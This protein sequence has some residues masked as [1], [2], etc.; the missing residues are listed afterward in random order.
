MGYKF[1]EQVYV[2]LGGEEDSKQGYENYCEVFKAGK[3]NPVQVKMGMLAHR[4]SFT[5]DELNLGNAE[6]NLAAKDCK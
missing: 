4:P 1:N 3:A 5:D 2:D 6:I